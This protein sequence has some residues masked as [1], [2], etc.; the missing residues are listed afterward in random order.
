MRTQHRVAAAEKRQLHHAWA[1]EPES[2][3]EPY[4][5]TSLQPTEYRDQCTRCGNRGHELAE[6]PLPIGD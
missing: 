4:E 6:C 3:D 1:S 2:D 5:D